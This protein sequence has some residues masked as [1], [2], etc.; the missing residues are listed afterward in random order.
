M[1]ISFGSGLG[2]LIRTLQKKGISLNLPSS[3]AVSGTFLVTDSNVTSIAG[4]LLTFKFY[5]LHNE[6]TFIYT[7]TYN[8]SEWNALQ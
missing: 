2:L 7:T 4:S 5:W 3:T 8:E 1:P 6:Q